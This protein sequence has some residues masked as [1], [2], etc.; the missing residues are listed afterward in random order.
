MDF[1]KK[2]EKEIGRELRLGNHSDL[3]YFKNRL[4]GKLEVLT[5]QLEE[6]RGKVNNIHVGFKFSDSSNGSWIV[7]DII[8]KAVA[9]IEHLLNG[10]DCD[11]HGHEEKFYGLLALKVLQKLLQPTTQK[12]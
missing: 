6:E 11:C 9:I 5:T 8:E 2:I 1:R 12:G 7:S 3:M 4:L 10:H